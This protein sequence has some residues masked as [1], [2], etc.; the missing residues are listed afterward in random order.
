MLLFVVVIAVCSLAC[1]RVLVCSV[2]R[3][4]GCLIVCLF[5]CCVVRVFARERTRVSVMCVLSV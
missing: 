3:L 4:V 5:D 1:L 2:C